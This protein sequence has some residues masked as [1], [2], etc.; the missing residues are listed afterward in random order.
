MLAN[1]LMAEGLGKSLVHKSHLSAL[2]RQAIAT[3]DSIERLGGRN[4]S[5]VFLDELKFVAATV[6][7]HRRGEIDGMNRRQP[8]LRILQR[9]ASGAPGKLT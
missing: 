1:F 9:H 4:H 3:A 7:A 5:P 2:V 8:Y 6:A